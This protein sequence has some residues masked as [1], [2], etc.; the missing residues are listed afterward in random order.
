MVFENIKVLAD[1][2]AACGFAIVAIVTQL[3][4]DVHITTDKPLPKLCPPEHVG[5]KEVVI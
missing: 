2:A 4:G 5:L 1:H 3:N